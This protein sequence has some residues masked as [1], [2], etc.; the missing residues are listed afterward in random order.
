M[1]KLPA[2][3]IAA[4]CV[5]ALSGAAAAAHRSSHVI[6]IPLPDGSSAHV[7][8][9]GDIAPKVTIEPAS[10][11]DSDFAEMPV[12]ARF[13]PMIAQMN[14]E[15]EAMMR[16]AQQMAEGHATGAEPLVASFG[17]APAGMTSTTIVSFSNGGG[18]CTRTTEAVSQGPRKPAKVTSLVT[19]NC[20]AAGASEQSA[21]PSAPISRT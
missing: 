12:F 7:E 20:S 2:T 18:T 16:S 8:Y 4:L 10:S 15:S 6:E 19:G 11:P 21:Q 1:R 9:V 17:S 13:D 5:T 3:A 14:R